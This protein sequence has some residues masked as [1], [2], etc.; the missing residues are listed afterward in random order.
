MKSKKCPDNLPRIFFLTIFAI[1]KYRCD[2]KYTRGIMQRLHMLAEN[3]D[4]IGISPKTLAY[5]Q[6][7]Q[8]GKSGT[9][10][11]T[12]IQDSARCNADV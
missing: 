3:A 7:R 2:T 11:G 5:G 4:F 1:Q 10:A 6:K 8:N 9:Q 12:E